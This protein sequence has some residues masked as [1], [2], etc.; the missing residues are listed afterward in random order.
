MCCCCVCQCSDRPTKDLK[1]C[2]LFPIKCAVQV[3]AL[4]VLLVAVAQFLEIF[5]QLLNDWIDWWY[6]LVGVFLNVPIIISFAFVVVFFNKDRPSSRI[7]LRTAIILAII[8]LTLSA[9]WNSVYF[10]F[11]YKHNEV[12]T[13]N[14]GVGF[15]HATRKQEIVFSAYI[16][17]VVD[18]FFAYFI[19][20]VQNYITA[21]DEWDLAKWKEAKDA[22]AADTE[23]P[24]EDKKAGDGKEED[25]PLVEGDD[26]PAEDAPE[27]KEDGAE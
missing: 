5:Y 20:V 10:W 13:G 16:A 6:V 2:I 15:T 23:A 21:Y 3:I 24:A 27:A 4:L 18:C 11:F 26:K 14:D 25:A 7:L 17:L 19:C 1:C 12:T 9:I 22:K 8:S